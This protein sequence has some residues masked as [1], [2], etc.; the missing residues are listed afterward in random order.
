MDHMI[1]TSIF[2]TLS[3][4]RF[5]KKLLKHHFKFL[6]ITTAGGKVTSILEDARGLIILNT[7]K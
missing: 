3:I 1:D 4:N 6:K 2:I 7:G 5:I